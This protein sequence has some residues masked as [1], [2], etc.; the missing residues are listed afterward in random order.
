MSTVEENM[1][2]MQ[3]LDDA[4]NSQDW[5]TFDKRHAKDVDVFWPGQEKPTHSRPS[6]KEEAI[7]F[8]KIFPDNNVGNRPYKVLFGQGGLDVLGCRFHGNLQRPDER[9]RWK[10]Y[11]ADRKEVQS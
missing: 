9:P 3:T 6:H 1:H 10:S 4:W 8:F 5:V 11:P 2:L 7:A